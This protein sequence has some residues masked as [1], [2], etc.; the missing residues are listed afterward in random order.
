MAP[1]K[2]Q[3]FM[4]AMRGAFEAAVFVEQAQVE[5]QDALAHDGE[6][7]VAGLDHAGVDRPDRDLMG[8]V[9][10]RGNRPCLRCRGMLQQS[11]QWLVPVKAQTVGVVC[12]ALV[13]A[14]WDEQVDERVDRPRGHGRTDHVLQARSRKDAVH[15]KALCPVACEQPTETSA[16][17]RL[18]L[19]R[20][21]PLRRCDQLYPCGRECWDDRSLAAAHAMPL[22]KLAPAWESASR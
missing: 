7:E 12:L 22:I 8:V 19:A 10:L 6:A 14:G 16:R 15:L 1:S 3:A 9:A 13:P 4:Q 21:T 17:L 18:A 11:S 2:L 20:R 5:V